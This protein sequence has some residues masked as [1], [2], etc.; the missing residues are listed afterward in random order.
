MTTPHEMH[1]DEWIDPYE[2][3]MMV[4][5][6]LMLTGM[7]GTLLV[8]A[9]AFGIQVPSPEKQVNP[10]TI[11]EQGPFSEP[12][13]RDLGGGKYEAYIIGQIWFWNPREIRVPAGS[14]VTFFIT[15][16][17]VQHGFLLW[18]KNLN[19]Q[20]V[21]GQVSKYTITFDEPGEYPYLCHEYCGIGHHTMSGV[22]IVE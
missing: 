17:D 22:V 18:H 21:P 6:V 13:L 2:K 14:T 3:I 16:K 20:I 7:M 1:P 15:S 5:G 12:G 19:A 4:L 11:S 10:N 9:F 8:A